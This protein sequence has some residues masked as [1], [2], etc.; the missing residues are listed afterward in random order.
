MDICIAKPNMSK[1][2]PELGTN[3]YVLKLDI[4]YTVLALINLIFYLL[5][6]FL[7]T[8][9]WEQ[10]TAFKDCFPNNSYTISLYFRRK[11]SMKP[12]SKY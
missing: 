4:F 10:T 11:G 9:H 7:T 8:Y 1:Y 12:I 6:S 3:K 5:P 2:Y